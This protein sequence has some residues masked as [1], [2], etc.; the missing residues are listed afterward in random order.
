[1]LAATICGGATARA[2][3][4]GEMRPKMRSHGIQRQDERDAGRAFQQHVLHDGAGRARTA[5]QANTQRQRERTH[6]RQ[7][8][9]PAHHH[10]HGLVHRSKNAI[11]GARRSGGRRVMRQ[12]EQHHEDHHRKDG[13]AGRCGKGIGG[14]HVDQ[15]LAQW[16]WW[17]CRGFTD[18]AECRPSMLRAPRAPP[19]ISQGRPSVTAVPSTTAACHQQDDPLEAAARDASARRH[20]TWRQRCR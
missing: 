20:I 10:H 16:R 6:R 18:R 9:H 2:K 5:V 14:D 8:Q 4:S 17:R 15:P 11:N 12:R 19:A 3:R 1:M 13:A 7:L